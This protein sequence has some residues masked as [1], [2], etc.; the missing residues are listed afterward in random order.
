MFEKELMI[1]GLRKQ[2]GLLNQ[3]VE[4]LES[5]PRFDDF[6]TSVYRARTEQIVRNLRKLRKIAKHYSS[7]NEHKG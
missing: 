2:K 4:E 7:Y 5:K 6:E 1:L 3:L